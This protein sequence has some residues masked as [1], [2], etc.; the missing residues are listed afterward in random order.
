[1]KGKKRTEA[2]AGFVQ[3][4]PKK[5]HKINANDRAAVDV[6][7]TWVPPGTKVGKDQVRGRWYA[8]NA[9]ICFSLERSFQRWGDV[10]ALNLVVVAAWNATGVDCPH[11][12]LSEIAHQIQAMCDGAAVG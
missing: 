11:D 7:K 10:G 3:D 1:M 9:T 8:R 5:K 6:A 4:N 12:W 2:P